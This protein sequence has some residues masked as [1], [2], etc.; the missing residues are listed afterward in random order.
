MHNVLIL[1]A[2]QR[3]ALSAIRSL[4]RRGLKVIAADHQ[5]PSIGSVSKHA[6]GAEPYADPTTSPEAFLRDI[7]AI[8]RRHAIDVVMPMTDTTTMLL[9]E[10]PDLLAPARLACPTAS[11]YLALTDKGN[12][13]KLAMELGVPVPRT[14]VANTA[15]QIRAAARELGYPLVLKPARSRFLTNGRIVATGV[16]AVRDEAELLA[17]VDHLPW[18]G[19][20]PCLVQAFVGEH[21]AG[22]FAVCGA[23]GPV[24]WFA[25][26]R[27]REKPP[28]GGVSVLS[29]S[30]AID[31][32]LRE[33]A[34][35]L[36]RA[37]RWF[38]VAMVEFRVARDGTPYLMEVNGRFWGSLQLAVDSGVDFPWLLHELA[39]GRQPNPSTGYTIGRRLRWLLGDVDNLLIQVRDSR[40]RASAKL[41]AMMQFIASCFDFGC[42]QE[43][44]RWSDPRPGW[45][46]VRQWLAALRK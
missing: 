18:L 11:S 36:L 3:S 41:A 40:K 44:L 38:G 1:D 20:I 14:V 21:G 19:E 39:S 31:A 23:E 26:R 29:E 12:L 17:C 28:S 13:V 8:V 35:A 10:H 6:A 7:T 2:N 5:L 42:R 27:I 46:E 32:R 33:H 43:V 16:R 15:E 25:H 30:A 24:A 4:G 45:L 9:V 34:A 22:V 37:A